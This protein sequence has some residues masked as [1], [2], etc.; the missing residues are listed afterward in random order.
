MSHESKADHEEKEEEEELQEL[1]EDLNGF[2][3][4]V[5]LYDELYEDKQKQVD[6]MIVE[7]V[8]EGNRLG[9]SPCDRMERDEYPFEWMF[10]EDIDDDRHFD[11][12]MNMQMDLYVRCLKLVGRDVF[13]E[14]HADHSKG[15]TE[16]CRNNDAPDLKKLY[17]SKRMREFMEASKHK[18]PSPVV[19][20]ARRGGGGWDRAKYEESRDKKFGAELDEFDNLLRKGDLT[21]PRDDDRAEEMIQAMRK[22]PKVDAGAK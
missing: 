7:Y 3:G 18:D 21:R 4:M 14:I 8:T 22:R 20:E 10:P 1:E 15:F 13:A 2:E 6:A 11:A 19:P 17:H 9:L 12:L 16:F 5:A